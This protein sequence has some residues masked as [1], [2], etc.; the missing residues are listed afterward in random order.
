MLA[1][2]RS[3]SLRVSLQTWLLLLPMQLIVGLAHGDFSLS[4][5]IPTFSGMFYVTR[6]LYPHEI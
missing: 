1:F 6:G 3:D 5:T 2:A 4:A